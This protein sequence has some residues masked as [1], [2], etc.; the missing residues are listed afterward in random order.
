MCIKLLEIYLSVTKFH[1]VL[2]L[3]LLEFEDN[4]FIIP[5]PCSKQLE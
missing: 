2:L 4:K 5:S 1:L 3:L